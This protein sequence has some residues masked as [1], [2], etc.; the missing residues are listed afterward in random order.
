MEAIRTRRA[1][2]RV[3]RQTFNELHSLS[4]SELADIGIHRTMIRGLAK[5]AAYGK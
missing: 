4:N 5:E 3:F 1:R 2:N